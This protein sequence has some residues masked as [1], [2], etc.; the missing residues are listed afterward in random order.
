MRLVGLKQIKLASGNA[1]ERTAF[2]AEC[3]A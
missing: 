2:A 1:W 3:R